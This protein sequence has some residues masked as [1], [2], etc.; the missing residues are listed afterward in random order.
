MLLMAC[1]HW[2]RCTRCHRG[3]AQLLLQRV[4][5]GLGLLRLGPSSPGAVRPRRGSK[6]ESLR[7]VTANLVLIAG[8]TGTG[9]TRV[10]E[11]L[12]RAADLEGLARHRGSAFGSLLD[13]QPSQID[14]ENALSIALLKLLDADEQAPLFL[15]DE[16]R[17]IGRLYLPEVLRERMA[18]APL[19]VVED[20]GPANGYGG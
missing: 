18:Q 16:G 15:E 4:A 20:A 2:H 10:I 5:D 13:P 8:R 1:L 12:S 9:K 14:F 11:A 7:P 17:L 19:Y 3:L 6:D